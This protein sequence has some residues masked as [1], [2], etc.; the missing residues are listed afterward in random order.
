MVT[1]KTPPPHTPGPWTARMRLTPH[2]VAIYRDEQGRRCT[3]FVAVC[4]STTL[5]NA[6]NAHLIAGAPELLA[7]CKNALAWRGLDGDGISDP[8]RSQLISALAKAEAGRE[9]Q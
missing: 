4:N 5:A 9:G 8:V 2:V 7:A 6:S 1:E 3:A